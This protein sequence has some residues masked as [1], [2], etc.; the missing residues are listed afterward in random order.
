MNAAAKEG[1][2]TFTIRIAGAD[3]T[4]SVGNGA[5]VKGTLPTA[6]GPERVASSGAWTADHIYTLKTVRYLTPFS[7]TYTLRFAGDELLLDSE[8][9]VGFGE[10]KAPQL[11]GKAD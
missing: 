2:Q 7:T 6:T 1:E 9:N 5:W 8:Q 10:R 4:V 3:H 11:I